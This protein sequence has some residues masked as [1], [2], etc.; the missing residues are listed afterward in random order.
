MDIGFESGLGGISTAEIILKD[1]LIP[2]IFLTVH[3]RSEIIEKI[4]KIISYDYIPKSAD[5]DILD[6][7]IKV[8]FK[9]F[10]AYNEIIARGKTI[11]SLTTIYKKITYP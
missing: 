4:E 10:E 3:A 9:L 7:S 1:H 2:V 5:I 8:A 11:S 6:A